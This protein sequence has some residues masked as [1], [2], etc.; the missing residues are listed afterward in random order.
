MLLSQ[1]ANKEIINFLQTVT[2]KNSYFADQM[3]QLKVR[4]NVRDYLPQEFNPYYRHISGEYILDERNSE[5]LT[6]QVVNPTTGVVE[7]Q[8]L[9]AHVNLPWGETMR[10]S[11]VYNSEHFDEVMYIT[12]LDTQTT[13]PFTKENL[14]VEFALAAGRDENSVHKKTLANYKL[15]SRYY[16]LLCEKYP[17]QVDL[18]KAIVYPIQDKS[19]A[20]AADNY[21][22][23]AYDETLLD[24]NERV[25]LISRMKGLMDVIRCRWDVKEYAFEEHYPMVIWGMIWNLLITHLRAQRFINIRT[26]DAHPMHIWEYLKSHGLGEYRGYLSSSQEMFL[27]RNL[28][29][30]L[31]N[32]GKQSTMN[33]LIDELLNESGID[34]K[35]KTVV[36][37]TSEVLADSNETRSA[38]TQCLT[39]TRKGICNKN[40]T[41]HTC[42]D[43]ININNECK[44]IP[45]I[46]TEDFAGSNKLK[47]Y[48]ILQT[49]YGYTYDEAVDKYSRSF[50]WVDKEIEEIKSR[51]DRDQ[52]VDVNASTETLDSLISREYRSGLEPIYNEDIVDE[53][54][55][56]LRHIPSTWL[57][58]KVLEMQRI[59]YNPKF[60]DMFNTFVTHT[61][62]RLASLNKCDITY[63][64]KV[65][66]ESAESVFGFNEMLTVLYLGILRA[67]NIVL[68]RDDVK[69]PLINWNQDV[70]ANICSLCEA[71]CAIPVV[72][73]DGKTNYDVAIPNK[74]YIYR[75][76]KFG[77]PIKQ[78][79]LEAG[80]YSES[81]PEDIEMLEAVGFAGNMEGKKIIEV[82]ETYFVGEAVERTDAS[83]QCATCSR[84]NYCSKQLTTICDEY[85]PTARVLG[86]IFKGAEDVNG[87]VTYRYVEN[88]DEIGIIPTY[89]KWHDQHLFA[90][91][92]GEGVDEKVIRPAASYAH[93]DGTTTNY[94][95]MVMY[96]DTTKADD[97]VI[98]K[99]A[100]HVNVDYIIDHYIDITDSLTDQADLGEYLTNMFKLMRIMQQ[101]VLGEGDTLSHLAMTEVFKALLY[102]GRISYDLVSITKSSLTDDGSIVA[103]YSDWLAYNKDTLLMFNSLD[104]TVNSEVVWNEFSNKVLD[105]LLEYCTLPFT[106]SN[107]DLT[108]YNKLKELV[109]RLSSYNITIIDTNEEASIGESM[110]PIVWSDTD[111]V[112]EETTVTH[113]EPVSASIHAPHVAHDTLTT[114]VNINTQTPYQISYLDGKWYERAGVLEEYDVDVPASLAD[115]DTMIT[116]DHTGV[117]SYTKSIRKTRVVWEDWTELTITPEQAETTISQSVVSE[118][119]HDDHFYAVAQEN[120]GKNE[121][122]VYTDYIVPGG[123]AITS[124]ELTYTETDSVDNIG[125]NDQL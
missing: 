108:K 77:K 112:I 27:Y 72:G 50:L 93:L 56:I 59:S 1:I 14:H 13:I 21:S 16:T 84:R 25:S 76:F 6:H 26:P 89:F 61:M 81:S 111:R 124:Q 29:Y 125:L 109:M 20:I 92:A 68:K 116:D 40:I 10:N 107:N 73:N 121:V 43:Y 8:T 23:L 60:F 100:N 97:G 86:T 69:P 31:A 99:V 37:D 82:G 80:V 44:A 115:A 15:P 87:N 79:V 74:A 71:N 4:D 95:E 105:Q 47:I 42:D 85:K 62:L 83:D 7:T 36:L 114:A 53:Q 22:V 75:S 38:A 41:S 117:V 19:A 78:E 35:A 18:I 70:V 28:R 64:F 58:T 94:S 32:R 30:I 122:I 48:D 103:T 104:Q 110:A 54:Y 57:P 11:L 118:S 45:V 120:I 55:N 63:R 67:N 102:R 34:L 5:Q 98:L 3:M 90:D 39:C 52:T 119:G 65:T 51:L 66:D 96:Y 123:K 88:G 91:N 113:V 24:A 101:T 2:I 46:L 33:I 106:A 9:N 49:E 12:S 17:K